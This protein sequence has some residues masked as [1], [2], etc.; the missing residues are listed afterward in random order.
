[1]ISVRKG[2]QGVVLCRIVI[3]QFCVMEDLWLFCFGV[4]GYRYFVRCLPFTS[5]V[6]AAL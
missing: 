3:I 5:D 1:M 4:M 2:F 6:C